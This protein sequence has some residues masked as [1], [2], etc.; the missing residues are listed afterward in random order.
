[1]RYLLASGELEGGQKELLILFGL[2]KFSIF[3]NL[4]L[5]KM[6][7]FYIISKISRKMVLD[8]GLSEKS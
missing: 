4:L 2:L 3:Q 6:N 5:I 7:Q 1:M 8:V